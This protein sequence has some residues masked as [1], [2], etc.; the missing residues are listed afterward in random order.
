MMR[1]VRRTLLAGLFLVALGVALGGLSKPQLRLPAVALAQ[2]MPAAGCCT[3][4][5]RC[6][7]MR[8]QP[9][10]SVCF[11]PSAYGPVGGRAC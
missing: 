6:G 9:M 5:G 2:S 4:F 8:P 1:L 11:C 7:L 10:G 3:Q